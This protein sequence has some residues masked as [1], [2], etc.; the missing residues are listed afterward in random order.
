MRA[1]ISWTLGAVVLVAALFPLHRGWSPPPALSQGFASGPGVQPLPEVEREVCRLTNYIRSQ[2]GLLLLAADPNLTEVSRRHSLD[3]LWRRFFSH[4]NR[5][6]MSFTDRLP[7]A[8]K[9]RI[10]G[11]GENI[12][13]CSGHYPPDPRALA[14]RMVDAWMSSPGHR[15]NILTPG[16]THLG[17][18]VAAVGGEVRATQVFIGIRANSRISAR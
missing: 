14:R 2:Y 11:A 3:M 5:E 10:S 12:W 17:V 7:P 13:T 16:F 4:Y 18:G 8:Y 15:R 1:K 9:T 6:G